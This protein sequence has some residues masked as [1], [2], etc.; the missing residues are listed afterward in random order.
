MLN[1]YGNNNTTH[2][3]L[4]R[5]ACQIGRRERWVMVIM[6]EFRKELEHLINKHSY[7]NGSDTPDFILADY[8]RDCLNAFD[9][10]VRKRET[11]WGR[12][13]GPGDSTKRTIAKEK[14]R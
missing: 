1:M 10:A 13:W 7:E 12:K 4:E 2:T 6:D 3:S 8:L 5:S 9:S 11:W 14:G